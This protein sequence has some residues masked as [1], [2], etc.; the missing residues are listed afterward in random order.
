MADIKQIILPDGNTYNLKDTVSTWVGTQEEYDAIQNPDPTVTYFITNSTPFPIPSAN[1]IHYD[2]TSSGL[3]A[4]N[5]QDAIDEI[6]CKPI[7]DAV[8]TCA[9]CP[10]ASIESSKCYQIGNV[11]FYSARFTFGSTVTTSGAVYFELNK[12]VAGD[13]AWGTLFYD[14]G[15]LIHK[16][17]NS[18]G[19][20]IWV[21]NGTARINTSD[22]VGK[23][24]MF[25]NLTIIKA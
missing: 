22:V 5:V 20:S 1:A 11:I 24:K 25:L 19:V 18:T 8:L 16:V 23:D 14:T 12:V 2:H 17:S 10:I 4:S 7:T 15:D 9:R 3:S 13:S 21:T 6:M